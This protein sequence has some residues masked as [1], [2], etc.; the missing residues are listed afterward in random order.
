M[1]KKT[2]N[3]CPTKCRKLTELFDDVHTNQQQGKVI[4]SSGAVAADGHGGDSPTVPG[5][6]GSGGK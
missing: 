1:R 3:Y 2:K 6:S 4:R 5:T